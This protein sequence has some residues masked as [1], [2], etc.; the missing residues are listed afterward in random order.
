MEGSSVYIRKSSNLGI[1]R[2]IKLINCF[3]LPVPTTI[4]YLNSVSYTWYCCKIRI[5][6]FQKKAYLYLYDE[7]TLWQY[8][9]YKIR[10]HEFYKVFQ[11]IYEYLKENDGKF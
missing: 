6:I 4:R 11:I 5:E 2:I 7:S 1:R 8:K 10:N 3:N 9:K